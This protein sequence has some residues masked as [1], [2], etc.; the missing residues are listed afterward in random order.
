MNLSLPDCLICRKHHGDL[1]VP[2]GVIYEDNL[3]YVSHA[4]IADGQETVYLGWCVVE[5]KRH[6]PGLPD[7]TDEEAQRV[8]LWAARLSR[9]IQV[10]TGAEYVYA[11]VIG[12]E[13]RISTFIFS[14]A[15][16]A[17][18]ANIG[19]CMWMNGLAPRAV[20]RTK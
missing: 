17:R 20:V 9:A 10:C 5:T 18:R 19:G 12:M 16:L 2:V 3:I 13:Y 15:I 11:F 4:H 14:L 6:T 7:L 1:P 8:G